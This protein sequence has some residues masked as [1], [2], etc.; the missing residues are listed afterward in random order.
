[1]PLLVRPLLGLWLAG[2]T[3]QAEHTAALVGCGLAGRTLC[4]SEEEEGAAAGVVEFK[5][6]GG[7]GA[8]MASRQRLAQVGNGERWGGRERKERE[9]SERASERAR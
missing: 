2:W 3:R 9:K 8:E 7:R 1:M 6:R 5:E 4:P